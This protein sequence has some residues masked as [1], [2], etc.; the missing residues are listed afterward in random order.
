MKLQNDEMQAGTGENFFVFFFFLNEINVMI[1]K[2]FYVV[3]KQSLALVDKG[4]AF[5]LS[6]Y[7]TLISTWVCV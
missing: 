2:I 4:S 6:D 1:F 3:G 7:P 5:V